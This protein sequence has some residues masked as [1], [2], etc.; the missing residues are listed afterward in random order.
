MNDL[1]IKEHKIIYGAVVKFEMILG[2]KG[3]LL[4]DGVGNYAA[5]FSKHVL[6][7]KRFYSRRT[8][9]GIE[10]TL[11]DNA[12]R[13]NKKLFLYMLYDKITPSKEYYF[14]CKNYEFA[15]K[16]E[17]EYHN[18]QWKYQLDLDLF[19]EPIFVNPEVKGDE[20]YCPPNR[21]RVFE[22]DGYRCRQCG[23]TVANGAILE[24]GHA[25]SKQYIEP[26]SMDYYIT[27]CKTCNLSQQQK[28]VD[29]TQTPLKELKMPDLF[30]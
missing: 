5:E 27:L 14:V 6:C 28:S 26:V 11:L 22:R 3:R 8:K 12:N 23:N 17:L 25:V 10:R 29:P 24:L 4:R 19:F 16:A 9:I 1:D 7:A 15:Q 13:D 18:T 30:N 21:L 2:Q 20:I